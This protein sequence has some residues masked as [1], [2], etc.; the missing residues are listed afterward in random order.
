MA[1]SGTVG[2][3][4]GTGGGSSS[5]T[6]ELHNDHLVFKQSGSQVSRIDGSSSSDTLNL[7]GSDASTK[8]DVTGCGTISCVEVVASSD[9]RLKTNI[10][11]LHERPLSLLRKLHGVRFDWANEDHAKRFGPQV[12]CIAQ[13]VQQVLPEICSED[14]STG[15]LSVDY[16]KLSCL[17]LECLREMAGMYEEDDC[18]FT[19]QESELDRT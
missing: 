12:G 18:L 8:C 3:G 1:S 5:S 7:Q 19:Q 10:R 17:L 11:R 16:S 2:S 13:D 14:P 9:R 6:S 15:T 4:G